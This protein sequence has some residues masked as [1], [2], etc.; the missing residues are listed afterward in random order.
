MG[1]ITLSQELGGP[2]L[3]AF[4]ESPLKI[5]YI[6]VAGQEMRTVGLLLVSTKPFW[7]LI[8]IFGGHYRRWRSWGRGW[9]VGTWICISPCWLITGLDGH[10][11]SKLPLRQH[12]PPTSVAGMYA[13]VLAS[14]D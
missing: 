5:I 10:C 13:R 9:S 11:A 8:S 1:Y 12:L 2:Y 14:C 7:G 6:L 4:L 3:K